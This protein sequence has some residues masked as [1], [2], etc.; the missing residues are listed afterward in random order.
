[1][2]PKR[3]IQIKN[4]KAINIRWNKKD[5]DKEEIQEDVP[6][7]KVQPDMAVI[8]TL[9]Q[10][11]GFQRARIGAAIQG[12][13]FPSKSTFYRHQ[14]KLIPKIKE[15][16]SEHFERFAKETFEQNDANIS[17]DGRYDSCRDAMYCT[18]ATMDCRRNKV[19]DMQTTNKKDVNVASNMLESAAARLSFDQIIGKWGPDCCNSITSDNDNKTPNQ[20]KKAG[21]DFSR[22]F[23]PR[24]GFQCMS[25]N[26]AKLADK[27]EYD[28]LFSDEIETKRVKI[29]SWGVYLVTNIEDVE[30]RGLMWTNSPFHMIGNHD[31]CSHGP[32]PPSH[33]DWELGKNDETAFKKMQNFFN[34]TENFIKNCD[35][36]N[37][38]QC[39]E[40]L[41][42]LISMLAPKRLY[43]A[44]SY[45]VRTLLAGCLYNDPH[46]FSS[47]L[48]DL[49]LIK[50]VPKQSLADI[51]SFENDREQEIFRKRTPQYREKKALQKKE[52]L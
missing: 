7:K 26:F 20:A 29:V 25:R 19:V 2:A 48:T 49:D 12:N 40:S 1:M 43:F 31:N 17:I 42:N 32:L 39:N 3:K 15:C 16:T 27:L 47:L 23:D 18:T 4:Q 28:Y 24:H 11:S 34:K 46:F 37:N 8:S 21:L 41:N 44:R 38:T 6:Y 5:D 30:L 13:C 10:G 50:F 45:E 9:V 33:S 22:T 36:R 14:Q 52:I 51:L 35:F